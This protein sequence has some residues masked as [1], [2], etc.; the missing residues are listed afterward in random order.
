MKQCLLVD[1]VKSRSA[2]LA[3]YVSGGGHIVEVTKRWIEGSGNPTGEHA[4]SYNK[5][6][7]SSN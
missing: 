5:Y 3:L 2:I 6:S 7:A 4:Y 1:I